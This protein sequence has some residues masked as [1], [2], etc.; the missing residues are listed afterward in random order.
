MKYIL[1][2]IYLC[3]NESISESLPLPSLFSQSEFKFL[4]SFCH[5]LFLIIP[6][7]CSTLIKQSSKRENIWTRE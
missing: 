6:F 7:Y 3:C 4:P 1:F 5:I 2:Q